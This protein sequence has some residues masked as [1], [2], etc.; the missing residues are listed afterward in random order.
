[1]AAGLD[2]EDMGTAGRI[3]SAVDTVV[4]SGEVRTPDMGGAS[5]TEDYTRAVIKALF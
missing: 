1:M 4:R 2:L 5:G 3:R